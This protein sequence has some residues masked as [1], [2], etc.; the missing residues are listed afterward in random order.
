VSLYMSFAFS[1]LC[2]AAVVA[3]G[4]I[5]KAVT[6]PWPRIRF[7][8]TTERHNGIRITDVGVTLQL[9]RWG[10]RPLSVTSQMLECAFYLTVRK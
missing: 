8:S 7:S 5:W 3:L 1:A 2:G 6:I 10:K 4:V 9:P